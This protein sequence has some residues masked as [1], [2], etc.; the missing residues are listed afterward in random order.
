[1]LRGSAA[2]R[3]IPNWPLL[4]HEGQASK[5][6]SVTRAVRGDVLATK[7]GDVLS[8]F[9]LGGLPFECMETREIEAARD[10]LS[11]FLRT[12]CDA[13]TAAYI[14]TV[15]RKL[16]ARELDSREKNAALEGFAGYLSHVRREEMDRSGLF[17]IGHYLTLI[18]R[19]L[20]RPMSLF[21]FGKNDHASQQKMQRSEG[22]RKL[23][24]VARSLE[25]LMGRFGPQRLSIEHGEQP[26]LLS[27]LSMLVN[28]CWAPVRP[29]TTGL[30]RLIPSHRA[31][32]RGETIHLR[33]AAPE[34]ERF[35]AMMALKGYGEATW[36]GALNT[37]LTAPV[38]FI[39]T[40]SFT[41]RDV[42][43]TLTRMK[44]VRRQMDV[45]DDE[46]RSL[47]EGLSDAMDDVAAAREVFGDHHMSVAVIGADE[48]DLADAASSMAS[49]L[50]AAGLRPVREDVALEALWWAQIP[51][52]AGYRARKAL[53]SATN[54]ADLAPAHS[55]ASGPEG[56]A[57]PWRAP[58]A[59]LETDL[60]TPY[61]FSFHE[62]GA[63]AAGSTLVFGPSGSGKTALLGYLLA[64][65]R[66]LPRP[67]RI[68]YFDNDRGAEAT[69]RALGGTYSRICADETGLFN[70]FAQA[71]DE[72]GQAWLRGWIARRIGDLTNEQRAAITDAVAM[73]ASAPPELRRFSE[74]AGLF[75]AL[76]DGGAL[77]G[78]L[79][80]WHSKGARA[81]MFD[82]TE[83]RLDLSP[84]ICGFDMTAVL[85]DPVGAE[86]LVDYLFHRLSLAL[87]S[88][89]PTIIVLDEAWLLIKSPTF[90]AQIEDWLKTIRKLN[91]IVVFV[92]QEPE[93]A[94]RSAIAPALIGG[95]TTKVF[96][97]N[98][99]ADE[100]VY[101]D[102]FGLTPREFDLVRSTPREERSFLVK[103]GAN[104]SLVRLDLSAHPELLKVLSGTAQSVAEL[105][106][107][108]TEHGEHWLRP[109]MGDI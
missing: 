1:M 59:T 50:T 48:T 99:T 67:P 88:G 43:E 40:H 47:A 65:S 2:L 37:M 93:D 10:L 61:R 86:A 4:R 91:G 97:P 73:N 62:E 85:R 79:S 96:Y 98:E 35:A 44:W 42:S 57:L 46:A 103:Q 39:A 64:S 87:E 60:G 63:N 58:I 109:F 106:R 49:V 13:R 33:G 102:V 72:R 92:S 71:I 9:R 101:R 68:F 18:R 54:L 51:G 69:I 16:T 95:T 6:I 26:E 21:G 90:A 53:I 55:P 12:A 75:G 81:W 25:S 22:I 27:F 36:P 17:E 38:E 20:I 19:P 30:D 7:N 80:D 45:A 29:E 77:A 24:E 8:V 94:A 89:E 3:S 76:D 100:G 83:D 28:G 84:E 52:N 78:A 105:D 82:G 41:P 70:P 66:A 34:D 14:Y 32:F 56:D 31:V 11:R 74:F 5:R 107:M 15:K 23:D 104:A 108:R